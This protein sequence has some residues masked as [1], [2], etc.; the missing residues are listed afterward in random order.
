MKRLLILFAFFAAWGAKSQNYSPVK[1]KLMTEWGEKVTPENVWR[2]YPRPQL[3]RTDW[4]NLNGLWEYAILPKDDKQPKN[5]GGNI[6]VPFAVESSLSG[7]GRSV[8]P[9]E[10]LWYQKK[11]TVPAGWNGKNVVLHFESV[12]WETTVWVNGKLVGT[13]KGGSTA[14]S[15]DITKY[16]KK[17]EQELVVSVWDPTDT[18]S[19]ARGKQVLDPKGIWYTAVTGIWKT[20]WIEPVGK[21]AIK[22]VQPVADID[23]RKVALHTAFFG[24]KGN[25]KLEVKVSKDGKTILTKEFGANNEI[26]L[27]IPSPELW[28]P[29]SPALYQLDLSL[30]GSGKLLD[31]VGSYFAM[32][33][34]AKVKD[35]QGFERIQLNNETIFQYGTLDQGWWPDGLLTPPSAEAMLY[36]MEVLR[37][38]GFNMLRKHIKV[39]P[40]LYYY[41]ADSLGLLLWQDMVSGFETAKRSVQH[42]SWDAPNDWARPKESADQFEFEMKETIDQ[43]KFFPSIIT[44]VIFNEG[45]GQY[46]SKRVVE[47][48]MNYDPTRIIDG[49][50]GWTDRKVGHLNDAHQYPGPGM[51]PAELNPGRAIVLGEF[52]GLGLPV[53]NHLWN[54]NMRNWGYRTY[55]STP[56]LIKEYT[57]LMHNLYPLRYKGLA[58]AVYTQTTDVE[59]EV[60][61]LMTYDRKVI[62]IDPELL[63]ILHAP[64]YSTETTLVKNVV[65]DSHVTGQTIHYTKTDPGKDWFSKAA[66][67]SFS[68]VSGP[69]N[70]GKGE[71][72]W[73]AQSFDL[74]N[75]PNGISL[76][77][78]AFGKVKV[79]LNGKLVLDKRIIGKR[80][81]EDFNVSEFSEYLKKGKNLIAVEALD[82]ENAAPFDFGVYVY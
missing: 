75:L 5:F 68:S 76:K 24:L 32:R 29:E 52:G 38:M 42:V 80:H 9:D 6:L 21:T 39:E 31:K 30:Y 48:S 40:S 45:W 61:G 53:E 2:E 78:L 57:K 73:S 54:P 8:L 74:T 60:N 18:D 28:S 3:K 23:L 47:W 49:V 12:D 37:E 63:R 26:V 43:L 81:Y 82:F 14:F 65:K 56:E 27:D 69:L 11:F 55:S 1:G 34:I 36:D 50:S 46:E 17:G 35:E 16:L 25:E 15:F 72:V 44:W 77:I 62:K 51:E 67:G 59:G 58:A 4:Q 66:I 79:Y 13:H 19:Q 71:S 33:K 20:V 22:S 7:V 70:V 10:K 41:Y 64:L